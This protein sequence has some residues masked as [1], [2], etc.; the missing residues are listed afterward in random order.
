MSYVDMDTIFEQLPSF[1]TN[2]TEYEPAMTSS[3][4]DAESIV[5]SVLAAVATVPFQAFDSN[6]DPNPCPPIITTITNMLAKS[7][8]LSDSYRAEASNSELRSSKLL[9]DRAWHLLEQIVAGKMAIVGGVTT[10]IGSRRLG[11]YSSTRGIASALKYFDLESQLYPNLH[12]QMR[13]FQGRLCP[14]VSDEELAG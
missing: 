13:Q 1:Q 3:I 9:Y 10:G 8:F 2:Q 7:I 11:V 14:Y 5:D 6:A 12:R 4:A